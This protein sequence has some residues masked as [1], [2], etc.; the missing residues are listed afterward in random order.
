MTSLLILGAGGHGAVVAETAH[1]AGNW[2]TVGFLDDAIAPSELVVGCPVLGT[3]D[4]WADHAGEGG[5]LVVAIGRN[6]RR[7]EVVAR[8]EAEGGDLATVVHP[9]AIV[10]P[11]AIVGLGAV[12]FAGAVVNARASIGKGAI[13]NTGATIDHDSLIGDFAHVSPGAHI[14]GEVSVGV[15]SWIG[16]GAAVRE[17]LS[18]GADCTVGAGSSVVRDV[19][20]GLTVVGVPAQVRES[21]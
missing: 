20:A 14:A 5:Q 3:L 1:A 15:R 6:R 4:T 11:S 16:I 17:C 19:D 13:I 18:I 2:N 21:I 12:I 9:G 7:E 10:S 8:I